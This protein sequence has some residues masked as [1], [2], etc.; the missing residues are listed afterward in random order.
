MDGWERWAWLGGSLLL[1]VAVAQATWWLERSGK[2]PGWVDRLSSSRYAPLLKFLLRFL[3]YVAIPFAALFWGHDAVVGRVL[4]LQP[5]P[6]TGAMDEA[7]LWADW[8]R[9]VGWA[10]GLGV[11]AWGLLAAGGWALRRLPNRPASFVSDG[12]AWDALPEAV[13]HEVHWAFY[14]NAPV[15]ALGAYW[16]SWVGLGLVLLEALLNPRWRATLR[17]PYHAPTALLR[18]ALAVLSSVFFLQ[19]GNLWLAVLVHGVVGW[20]VMQVLALNPL[21]PVAAS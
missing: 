16:G 12:F 4:G 9:D 8:A 1:G 11:T 2:R 20:G 15:V 13:F 14:R 21:R 10:V 3:F 18:A 17:S 5:L 6:H 19:T 7:A